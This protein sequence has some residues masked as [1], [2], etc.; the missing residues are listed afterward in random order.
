MATNKKTSA[1]T[2]TKKKGGSP[3]PAKKV[4]ASGAVIE[5]EIADRSLPD[6]PA[7][8]NNP[9]KGV[10]AESSQIDLNDPSRS[11]EKAVAENLAAQRGE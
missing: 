4:A 6:H 1:K 7:V 8:E 5:P 9:R 2:A 11:P 10:P 3:K